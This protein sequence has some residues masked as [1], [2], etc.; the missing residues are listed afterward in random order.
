[1]AIAHLSLEVVSNDEEA[2][3]LVMQWRNDEQTLVNSFDGRPKQWP[4]FLEEFRG[5][6]LSDPTLPC[7]FVCDSGRRVAFVRFR[8]LPDL[9]EE[10]CASDISVNVA[11]AERG[12]GYGGA[13][14]NL[15][16]Q[17][18]RNA[19]IKYL[20]ADIKPDN[21]ASIAVF[22]KCGFVFQREVLHTAPGLDRPIAVKRF[23]LGTI[24]RCV[25]HGLPHV[26]GSGHC[27]VIAEAGS[28]WRMGT[29]ARDLKMG[30]ALID[31]AAEAGADAV[32]FQTYKPDTTY[33]SN[34]GESDYLSNAGIKESITD[35]FADL[36]MP[37]EMLPELADYAAK[38][39]ILF[40]SSPFSVA[41]LEAVD[42]FVRVHKIA[43]YEISHIRLIE[44]AART[45]KPAI[46]STGA[47][48]LEDIEWA[49]QHFRT[50]TQAPFCLMQ[51]TARYPAGL[52]NLNLGVI[53]I[54]KARFGVPVGLSDHTRDPVAGPLAAVALG[55]DLIEKHFTLDN[56]LP[57]PDHAFAV[58]ADELKQ[59]VRYIRMA[60]QVVGPACKSVLPEEEELFWYA[61]RG[62][63]ATKAIQKGDELLEGVN[64][65]I[66]RPGKQRRGA[67]PKFIGHV[68][69]GLAGRAI[70]LGDGVQ[71]EDCRN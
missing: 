71:L 12:K 61:R 3:K 28:N 29:P 30:K 24:K 1:M 60:E 58:T 13:A 43:S 50:F 52:N 51:C 20:V 46:F 15:S 62:L 38:Q 5:H 67:H 21:K 33:V 63:Q 11:P 49:T 35:I 10:Q 19:G 53:P 23:H 64:F 8:R 41:D 40:M 42:P 36:S 17:V 16:V 68:H 69:K 66:L 2:A 54:L 34:A 26:I 9:I 25:V 45:G 70:P 39:N 47:S 59:M 44:A 57:G 22:E 18:A 7:L 55:A 48:S 31:V 65:D 56:R 32:K 14:I 27:F 4:Q 6:Y 37:A